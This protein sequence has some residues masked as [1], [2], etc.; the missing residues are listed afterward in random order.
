MFCQKILAVLGDEEIKLYLF[1]RHFEVK[2]IKKCV[3]AMPN[4]D[5][6][7]GCCID[8]NQQILDALSPHKSNEDH[9][10]DM[11]DIMDAFFT[12]QSKK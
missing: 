4:H 5:N 12:V 11:F 10:K 9:M 3:E 6:L 7:N 8:Y 1:D 2:G